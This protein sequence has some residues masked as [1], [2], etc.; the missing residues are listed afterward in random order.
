MQRFA[1]W[2]TISMT[3]LNAHKRKRHSATFMCSISNEL[4]K[5]VAILYVDDCDLL[6]I[7]MT[8]N[9]SAFVTF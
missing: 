4:I 7:D 3:I 2:A 9:D 1:G 8:C 5:F 6:H